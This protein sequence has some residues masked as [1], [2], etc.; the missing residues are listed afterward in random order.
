MIFYTDDAKN[1]K[2]ID[3]AT[4]QFFNAETKV[5]TEIQVNISMSSMRSYLQSKKQSNCAQTK[6]NQ[7][8]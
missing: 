1:S 5:K 7:S 6:H 8:K 2:T 3:A 4:V